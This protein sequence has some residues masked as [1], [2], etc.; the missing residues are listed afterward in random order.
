MTN[1]RTSTW[2][3][4]K[5]WYT[6][7]ILLIIPGLITGMYQ[8]GG[9]VTPSLVPSSVLTN[10]SMMGQA[11]MPILQQAGMAPPVNPSLLQKAEQLSD[12]S[13][14]VADKAV[15]TADV[16]IETGDRVIR[17]GANLIDRILPRHSPEGDASSD[18]PILPHSQT[19]VSP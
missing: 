12:K 7:A 9:G 19:P 13:M 5:P 17:F 11:A 1:Q 3:N 8:F 14:T 6:V 10:P 18:F 16:T 15:D 4:P 2:E